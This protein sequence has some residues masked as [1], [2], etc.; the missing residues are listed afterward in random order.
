MA[1]SAHCTRYFS[2]RMETTEGFSQECPTCALQHQQHSWGDVPSWNKDSWMMRWRA[3]PSTGNSLLVANRQQS[4]GE[5]SGSHK[6]KSAQSH[7]PCPMGPQQ[8]AALSTDP[9]HLLCK[10]QDA[11]QPPASV[12]WPS[13]GHSSSAL[14]SST[15]PARRRQP[16]RVK[17]AKAVLVSPSPRTPAP[18]ELSGTWCSSIP[19]GQPEDTLHSLASTRSGVFIAVV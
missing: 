12:N 7:L 17:T 1:P 2:L 11:F 18:S 19:P 4:P 16:A 14:A 13:P 15:L 3:L 10:P 9:F 6:V 5:S 8:Q